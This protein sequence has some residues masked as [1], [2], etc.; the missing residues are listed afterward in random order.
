MRNDIV[1]RGTNTL[2]KSHVIERR[3]IGTF[4]H[5]GRVQYSINGICCD[6]RLEKDVLLTA[7]NVLNWSN[8][9]WRVALPGIAFHPYQVLVSLNRQ[10]SSSCQYQFDQE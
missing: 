1:Y 9:N 10:L 2:W 6:P 5:N 7:V 4:G 3:W 8:V